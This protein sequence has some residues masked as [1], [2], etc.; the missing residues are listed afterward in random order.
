[1]PRRIVEHPELESSFWGRWAR[2]VLRRP[3]LIAG[4]GIVIV[5]LL[6]IPGVQLNPAEAQAKDIRGGKA[7]D[8]VIGYDRLTA[9]GISPGVL[10]PYV[11]LARN[12]K[13]PAIPTAVHQLEATHGVSGAA[14]PSGSDW[15]KGGDLLIEAFPAEDGAA[16]SARGTISRLQHD[17]L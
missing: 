2:L 16:R 1:M 15:R 12:V 10:K 14:A 7:E 5:A 11:V 6:L 13:P 8:A 9:A 17:I 4:I 3:A